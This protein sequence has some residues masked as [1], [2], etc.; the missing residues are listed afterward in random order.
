MQLQCINHPGIQLLWFGAFKVPLLL[1]WLRCSKEFGDA[2]KIIY[3]AVKSHRTAALQLHYTTKHFS[4]VGAGAVNYLPPA[5][6][7]EMDESKLKKPT[8]LSQF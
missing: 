5:S 7:F 4:P 2:V 3:V 6:F 1:W 8:K